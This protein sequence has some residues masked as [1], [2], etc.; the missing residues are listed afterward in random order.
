[1]TFPYIAFSKWHITLQRHSMYLLYIEISIYVQYIDFL[2]RHRY[3]HSIAESTISTILMVFCL[4]SRMSEIFVI[5]QNR[6]GVGGGDEGQREMRA[7]E[8]MERGRPNARRYSG[9]GANARNTANGTLVRYPR[10]PSVLSIVFADRIRA[11]FAEKM[12]CPVSIP[13]SS[14]YA[15][16][17]LP[18][19]FPFIFDETPPILVHDDSVCAI[20]LLAFSY[21]TQR[22][23]KLELW[24]IEFCHFMISTFRCPERWMIVIAFISAANVFNNNRI[25]N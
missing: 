22:D 19:Q 15:S 13:S 18:F 2:W 1:M 5:I 4:T 16:P 9:F 20:V 21:V 10:F 17:C 7:E 23:L 14:F 6:G 11:P 8:R 25:S 24:F 12:L 3:I